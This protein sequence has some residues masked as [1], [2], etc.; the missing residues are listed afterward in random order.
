MAWTASDYRRG[1]P[2]A[3]EAGLCPP[4]PE[5]LRLAQQLY[6]SKPYEAQRYAAKMEGTLKRL[7]D[8]EW[9]ELWGIELPPPALKRN[10]LI[11]GEFKNLKETCRITDAGRAILKEIDATPA[12]EP[13]PKQAVS[14][15][16]K[17]KPQ[18]QA[19]K[20]AANALKC[21]QLMNEYMAWG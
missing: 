11:E 2:T 12:P 6:L 5:L 7:A 20:D 13:K 16:R 9:H 19:V 10:G 21:Q 4:H 1:L 15:M 17:V 3:E 8:G 18:P 14:R